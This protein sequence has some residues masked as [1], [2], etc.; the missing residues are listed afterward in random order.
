M[1]Y[2]KCFHKR[3]IVENMK[4]FL[5]CL[6]AAVLWLV[7]GFVFSLIV[8]SS[9]DGEVLFTISLSREVAVRWN[10]LIIVPIGV[11]AL[12]LTV[13]DYCRFLKKEKI[14]KTV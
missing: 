7:V 1:N 3:E 2:D 9:N 13:L 14:A 8:F 6:R 10:D 4:E 11:V 12:A 5:L